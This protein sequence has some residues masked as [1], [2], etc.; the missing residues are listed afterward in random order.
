MAPIENVADQDVDTDEE[1]M[2]HGQV[3]L[4]SEL[5]RA[6]QDFQNDSNAIEH[7]EKIPDYKHVYNNEKI[8]LFEEK[9]EEAN[10][11]NVQ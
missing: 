11:T 5:E 8:D 2:R 4:F 10:K 3:T 7:F 6:I 1:N 9:E